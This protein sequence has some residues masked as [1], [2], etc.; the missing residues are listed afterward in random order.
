MVIIIVTLCAT[1]LRFDI[2]VHQRCQNITVNSDILARDLSTFCFLSC[3]KLASLHFADCFGSANYCVVFVNKLYNFNITDII[4]E[5]CN[6]L[7]R[8]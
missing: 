5:L 4:R 7:L 8:S 3:R 1:R 2:F 6:F